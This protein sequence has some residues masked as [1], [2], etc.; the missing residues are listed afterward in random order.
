MPPCPPPPLGWPQHTLKSP[1]LLLYAPL[2]HAGWK[3]E[4]ESKPL[5]SLRSLET[6]LGPHLENA[7]EARETQSL[8]WAA[9]G[10]ANCGTSCFQGNQGGV[11]PAGAQSTGS[12]LQAV[13]VISAVSCPEKR[14]QQPCIFCLIYTDTLAQS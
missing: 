2:L 8:P 9:V 1:A 13:P 7:V 4:G 11:E 3:R 5:P 10:Q 6:A 14:M 12:A